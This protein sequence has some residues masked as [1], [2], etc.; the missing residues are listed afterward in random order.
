MFEEEVS[1]IGQVHCESELFEFELT[2]HPP[3]VNVKGSLLR[4]LEFWERRGYMLPFLSLPEPAVYKNNRSSLAHAEFVEDAILELVESEHVLEVVV[5]P[6][7]VNPLS[8]SV[9]ATGKKR[10]ILDLR[11]INKCL[12]KVR[13]KYEDWKIA[14]SY[15]MTNF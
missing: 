9:Q 6:L 5:P 10:L 7:V 12:R 13:L 15:L 2:D 14:L 3:L 8:V 1:D 4:K 11:Y